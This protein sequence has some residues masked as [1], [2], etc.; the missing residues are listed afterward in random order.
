MSPLSEET[1]EAS[2]ALINAGL[3]SKGELRGCSKGINRACT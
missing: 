1:F 2:L 3:Q